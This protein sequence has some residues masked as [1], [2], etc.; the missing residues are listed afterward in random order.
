M[1]TTF[2]A[3]L[4]DRE[5]ID[6]EYLRDAARSDA[7]TFEAL[8]HAGDG[9]ALERL[10]QT[11]RKDFNGDLFVAPCSF[12]ADARGP[13]LN[14]SHLTVLARFRAGHE[15]MRGRTGQYRFWKYDFKYIPI[16]LISA[17]HDRFPRRAGRR[18]SR[19]RRV[20]HADVPRRHRRLPGLGRA[21]GGDS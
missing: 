6:A 17:V 21:V 3:Y 18:E 10:F 20:L 14:A 15:E 5:I 9:E 16:G 12:E 2:I 1:Q 19:Q 13:R 4:E 7:E 11:L 8:L